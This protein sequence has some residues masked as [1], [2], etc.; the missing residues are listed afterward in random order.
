MKRSNILRKL[1]K[2]NK[3]GESKNYYMNKELNHSKSDKEYFFKIIVY[4]NKL[5]LK[6]N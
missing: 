4:R 2:L 1:L 6:M 5:Y 3:I